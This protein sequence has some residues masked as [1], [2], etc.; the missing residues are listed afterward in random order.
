[1][2]FVIVLIAA[3][4]FFVDADAQQS[5]RSLPPVID[6]AGKRIDVVSLSDIQ[7]V[8]A[9]RFLGSMCTH[10]M[11]QL[12]HFQEYTDQFREAG[13]VVVAF[14]DNETQ[15]CREVSKQY[16]FASDVFYLCSDTGNVCSKAYGT[17]IPERNGTVTELH[18]IRVI[19][20]RIQLFEH[21]STTP[22]MDVQYVLNLLKRKT[23]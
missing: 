1:M 14:S 7:P 12:A 15:K 6:T 3:L 20:K 13:A 8:V 4:I 21:Y 22:Y 10:C 18:G 19:H 17:S 11:Q 9:I 23:Q 5:L 16:G 2:R